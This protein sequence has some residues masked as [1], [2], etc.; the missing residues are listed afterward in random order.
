MSDFRHD[1]INNQWIA[2]AKNRNDRPMEFVPLE[3]LREHIIC[4]FCKGNEEETPPPLTAI[5][6]AGRP[7]SPQAATEDWLV[8]V[9]PNKFPSFAVMEDSDAIV[10]PTHSMGGSPPSSPLFNVNCQR[11]I[12]ELVIPSSRH[13][14]SISELND[15]ELFA[16]FR[17]SQQR[18]AR[19]AEIHE[20]AHAMFFMNCRSGAGASLGHIHYQLIGTPVVSD[21]LQRRLDRCAVQQSS[22][23]QAILQWELEQRQRVVLETERFCAICPFASRFA[24]Q[25]WIAPKVNT[26]DF[27]NCRGEMRDELAGLCRELVQRLER[28]L[29]EPAYNMLLHLPPFTSSAAGTNAA[30]TNAA[31]ANAA[32]SV[33]DRTRPL[34]GDWYIELFPRLTQAAGYE[35]GTDIWINPVP[36]ETAARRLRFAE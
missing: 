8:R 22:M 27:F 26:D 33:K 13:L 5:D 14:T 2:I 29:G 18:I 17:V 12:Q 36:P 23:L 1:P 21:H 9:V 19:L 20:I 15:A 3:Q 34:T 31:S 11:G 35:W 4:P 28:V 6:T 7:L 16:S 30:G 32:D 24:F 25:I 10:D